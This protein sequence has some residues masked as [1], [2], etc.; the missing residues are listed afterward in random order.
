MGTEGK[1][2]SHKPDCSTAAF[3]RSHKMKDFIIG[4]TKQNRI[5]LHVLDQLDKN[6]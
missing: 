4:R 3:W 2:V 6:V 1:G 5:L